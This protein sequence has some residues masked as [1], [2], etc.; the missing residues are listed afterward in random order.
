M[1]QLQEF[2]SQSLRACPEL[3]VQSLIPFKGRKSGS[4]EPDD[5]PKNHVKSLD[6]RS[7]ME[8]RFPVVEGYVVDLNDFQVVC[9]VAKVEPL[10]IEPLKTPT[11]VF[12]MPQ[13]GVREGHVGS[14]DF[15]TEEHDREEFYEEHHLQTIHFEATC[16]I[17][18][19]LTDQQDGKLRSL[20][21]PSALSA[22]PRCD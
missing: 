5:R 13:V 7:E 19:R 12:V 18:M 21:R 20:S 22:D 3:G 6:E 11:S 10:K 15:Q 8:I 4:P 17:L 2:A 9:D 1:K 16:Q 14:M